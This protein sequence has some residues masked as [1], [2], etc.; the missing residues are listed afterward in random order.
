[1]I[2]YLHGFKSSPQS[3][4]AQLLG[5]VL[6][7]RG[8]AT[9]YVCPQLPASPAAAVALAMEIAQQGCVSELTIIGSSLGGF[10]AT[11]M[12]EQ[13]GCRAVLLNPAVK[14]PHSLERYVGT[15]RAYHSDQ[16]FVFKAS[17]IN[18]LSQLTVQFITKPSRYFLIAAQGDEVLNWRDMQA[19]YKQARQLIIDGS[20]HGLS[21]FAD[22]IDT[23]LRF[24][25]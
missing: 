19:H 3:F 15:S 10:Y 14:A 18:E 9:R 4:K 25:D 11:W 5:D 20:D 13:L 2:L 22:Y 17:Y 1:M 21:D 16:P 7:A 8:Q 6:A 23:V 24:C 12:A